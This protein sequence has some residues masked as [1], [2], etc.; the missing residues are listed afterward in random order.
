MYA[1]T[2][3]FTRAV[4][5]KIQELTDTTCFASFDSDTVEGNFSDCLLLTLGE[6]RE[7]VRGN[8]TLSVDLTLTYMVE[9]ETMTP[10]E[11]IEQTVFFHKT[12]VEFVATLRR[13]DELGGAVFLDAN[14]M[15]W[16]LDT[17]N[18]TTSYSLPMTLVVQF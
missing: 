5:D 11:V 9:P 13:Y 12:L 7:V 1:N 16:M 17:E 4:A 14:V 2:V 8:K 6:Q 15:D 3:Q 10:A 18:E